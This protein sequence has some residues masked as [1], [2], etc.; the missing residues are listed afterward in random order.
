MCRSAPGRHGGAG[1]PFLRFSI[2][3][4]AGRDAAACGFSQHHAM[5]DLF[6]GAVGRGHRA[7]HCVLL[8]LPPSPPDLAAADAFA[9]LS[10]VL[11]VVRTSSSSSWSLALSV[12]SFLGIPEK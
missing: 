3:R 9:V 6:D 2:V 7:V 12:L 8:H 5:P 10:R 1:N 4:R 11:S